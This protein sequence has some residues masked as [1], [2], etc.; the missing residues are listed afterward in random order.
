[1]RKWYHNLEDEKMLPYNKFPYVACVHTDQNSVS[2]DKFELV[3]VN[4]C[5]IDTFTAIK[6]T[7][8]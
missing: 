6:N 5:K 3:I 4:H 8:G 1:M 2:H 7:P